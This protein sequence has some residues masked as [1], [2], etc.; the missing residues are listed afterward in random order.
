MI[1]R[2]RRQQSIFVL[3]SA[4][5]AVALLSQSA[6]AQVSGQLTRAEIDEAIRVG[7]E[8]AMRAGLGVKVAPFRMYPVPRT[9]EQVQ[10]W[11]STGAR[12]PAYVYTPFVRVALY[13]E[14]A[15]LRGEQVTESDLPRR[16]LES[17]V[18]IAFTWGVCCGEEIEARYRDAKLNIFAV[19]D[20]AAVRLAPTA[21]N[22]GGVL[23]DRRATPLWIQEGTASLHDLGIEPP[24]NS[25]AVAAFSPAVVNAARQFRLSKDRPNGGGA[26][27]FVE[28]V[29]GERWR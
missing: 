13:A 12:A 16:L 2:G 27:I 19:F 23:T 24:P 29:P 28:A 10:K 5:L 7:T 18:H 17:I 25:G 14:A 1:V 8:A 4:G 22:V 20:P 15:H 6:W 9:A 3:A 26:L 11:V 21:G